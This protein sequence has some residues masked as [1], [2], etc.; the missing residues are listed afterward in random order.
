MTKNKPSVSVIMPAYNASKYIEEAIESVLAQT[1]TDFELIVVDDQSKDSTPEKVLAYTEKDS[2]V[3][4]FRNEKNSGS[5]FSRNFGISSAQGEWIALLDCDDI[6]TPD[7][8]EKQ[9]ALAESKNVDFVFTGSAFTDEHGSEYRYIFEVPEKITYKEL[10]KQN[11]ISCSSVLIKKDYIIKYKMPDFP[12]REDFACWLTILKTGICAYGINEPLLIYRVSRN[13]KSSNKKTA[14]KDTFLLYRAMGYNII[15]TLY[16]FFF[17]TIRS[18]KKY[19][20]IKSSYVP[21][22]TKQNI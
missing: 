4:Y 2:R 10:L 11:I 7:K 14:A 12:M 20:N 5:S 21:S 6:W 16:Y 17:Y 19:K 13:S 8:L 3:K 9:I 18:L 15:S 22:K 1:Y